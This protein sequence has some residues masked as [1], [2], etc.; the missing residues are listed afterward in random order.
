MADMLRMA[1]IITD[2]VNRFES[3]V[4]DSYFS[5]DPSLECISL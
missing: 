3:T 1:T 5:Q 2:L 4:P